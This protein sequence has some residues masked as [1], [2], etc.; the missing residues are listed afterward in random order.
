MGIRSIIAFLLWSITLP[1]QGQYMTTGELNDKLFP[2]GRQYKLSGWHGALGLTRAFPVPEKR[3]ETYINN[4]DTLFEADLDPGGRTGWY[5]E[6]GRYRFLPA[7]KYV[8]YFDYSLAYKQ[9]LG[10]EKFKGRFTDRQDETNNS[11]REVQSGFNAHFLTANIN[12]NTAIQLSDLSF[13]QLSLGLNADWRFAEKRVEGH[14]QYEEYASPGDYVGQAH[15]KL[16]YG[17]RVGDFTYIIP[18]LETPVL[19]VY[20]FEDGASTL[21]WYNSRYRPVIL[22]LRFLILS[23]QDPED[24]PPVHNVNDPDSKQKQLDEGGN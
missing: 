3:K 16:G 17:R 19:N 14:P 2:K 18:T 8:D 7:I 6:F 21:P 22:T 9:L 1:L 10:R 20:R 24:C 5:L 12:A 13:L 23:E 11:I 15:F 4:P